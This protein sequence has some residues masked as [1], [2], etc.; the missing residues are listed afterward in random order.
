MNSKVAKTKRVLQSAVPTDLLRDRRTKAVIS[1][2]ADDVGLVY[3][4]YTSQRNDE[5]RLLRGVTVS[6]S[7]LDRHYSVGT[8]QGYDVALVVRREAVTPKNQPAQHRFWT[9]M[10]FDLHTTYELPACFMSHGDKRQLLDGKYLNFSALP[11]IHSEA[12]TKFAREWNL[13]ANMGQ[14]LEV[15]HLLSDELLNGL[16]LHF[17]HLAI[18]VADNT[19]YLYSALKHP[20]RSQLERQMSNGLW[21]ARHLDAAADSARQQLRH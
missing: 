10:T 1:K 5:H 6:K 11:M 16:S 2:F 21:L 15:Q 12:A 18:E 13:Y 17:D 8:F 4:G 20:T 19:V 9:I 7:H 3:F 14:A